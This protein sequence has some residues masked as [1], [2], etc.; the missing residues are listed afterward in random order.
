[1]T[2]FWIQIIIC[3]NPT[4]CDANNTYHN[5]TEYTSEMM[6]EEAGLKLLRSSAGMKGK[7]VFCLKGIK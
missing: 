3:L 1:M 7:V 2:Q 4:L 6:C 5:Y